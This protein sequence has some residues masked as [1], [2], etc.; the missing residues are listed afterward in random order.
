MKTYKRFSFLLHA[1]CFIFYKSLSFFPY[2]YDILYAFPSIFCE[3]D[4][5]YYSKLLW[6]NVYT[7]LRVVEISVY[8]VCHWFKNKCEGFLKFIDHCLCCLHVVPIYRGVNPRG[9]LGQWSPPY[10]NKLEGKH[11]ALFCPPPPHTHNC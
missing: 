11:D 4:K 8:F 7:L 3:H 5:I 10:V 1:S 2:M 9:Q 6:L